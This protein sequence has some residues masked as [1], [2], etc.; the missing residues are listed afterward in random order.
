VCVC[1]CVCWSELSGGYGSLSWCPLFCQ[2]V[3]L[4][5]A[6]LSKTNQAEN[7]LQHVHPPPQTHTHGLEWEGAHFPS[8]QPL[9]PRLITD[10]SLSLSLSFSLSLS[11]KFRCN[12][13]V[14]VSH[15]CEYSVSKIINV[16]NMDN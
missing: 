8:F 4:S 12:Q 6:V 16:T 2:F 9:H 11:L 5:P 1:V 13:A 3:L 15:C 14:F 7:C 10:Q